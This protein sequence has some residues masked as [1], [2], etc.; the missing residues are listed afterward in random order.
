M[1]A[2][3]SN[4]LVSKHD[5]STYK[6]ES[7]DERLPQEWVGEAIVDKLACFNKK[8]LRTVPISQARSDPEAKIFGTRWVSCNTHDA[9]DPDEM[10]RLVVQ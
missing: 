5:R 1:P 9:Q 8:V 6:D 2:A 10:A 3:R 7:A 4:I